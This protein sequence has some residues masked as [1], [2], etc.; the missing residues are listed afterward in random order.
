MQPEAHNAVHT[1][2]MHSIYNLLLTVQYTHYPHIILSYSEEFDGVIYFRIGKVKLV[3]KWPE[4]K[5]I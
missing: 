5:I 3:A 2:T 4:S 1:V